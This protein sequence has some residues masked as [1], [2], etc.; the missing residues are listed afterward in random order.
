MA[1]GANFSN[2]NNEN[3]LELSNQA[4]VHAETIMVFPDPGA[5]KEP[6]GAGVWFGD[7]IAANSYTY[8]D[9]AAVDIVGMYFNGIR[10][11]PIAIVSG[12]G[13]QNEPDVIVTESPNGGKVGI[14]YYNNKNDFAV[15]ANSGGILL[16]SFRRA[17]SETVD[18]SQNYGIELKDDLGNLLFSSRQDTVLAERIMRWITLDVSSPTYPLSE[19][20]ALTLWSG[21]QLDDTVTEGEYNTRHGWIFTNC[22]QQTMVGP[23]AGLGGTNIRPGYQ[24]RWAPWLI[25]SGGLYYAEVR[26][27][28]VTRATYDNTSPY[29]AFSPYSRLHLDKFSSYALVDCTDLPDADSFRAVSDYANSAATGTLEAL[30]TL[31]DVS[32]YRGEASLSGVGTAAAFI[33]MPVSSDLVGTGDLVTTESSMEVLPP[34]MEGVLTGTTVGELNYVNPTHAGDAV[35]QSSAQQDAAAIGTFSGLFEPVA[36]GS[37]AADGEKIGLYAVAS[38][39][40]DQV[41]SYYGALQW[42]YGGGNSRGM[43]FTFWFGPGSLYNSYNISLITGLLNVTFNAVYVG[44]VWERTISVSVYDTTGA[45]VCYQ[46]TDPT[47]VD[48]NSMCLVMFSIE[49]YPTPTCHIWVANAANPQG[50]ECRDA[51]WAYASLSGGS[52]YVS[53]TR[54]YASFGDTAYS[55]EAGPFAVW[56]EYKDF[57]SL[58]VRAEFV[59]PSGYPTNIG[60][61]GENV[62]GYNAVL[63]MGFPINYSTYDPTKWYSTPAPGGYNNFQFTV[64]GSLQQLPGWVN[65]N[66]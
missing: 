30:G 4:L 7:K 24:L 59:A 18:T 66:F 17:S 64:S 56:G 48:I 37:Q 65:V 2:N 53:L 25:P 6:D 31:T 49:L 55:M 35:L 23:G 13:F 44:G 36:A 22:F 34:S 60:P 46:R 39:I 57:S 21:F 61:D 32:P 50:I 40:N 52:G 43:A 62:S 14:L 19:D 3:L 29:D 45:S 47:I 11:S 38:F 28:M 63:V 12:N 26:A 5:V 54:T 10:E 33:S 42:P 27:C 16:H 58:S 15:F 9:M 41:Y 8:I 51:D 1:Y 20:D